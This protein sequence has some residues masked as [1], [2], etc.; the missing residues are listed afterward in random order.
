MIG[1]TIASFLNDPEWARMLPAL[2][3]L[4]THEHGIADLEQR[5]ERHQEEVLGQLIARG[6]AEGVLRADAADPRR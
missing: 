1:R 4:K 5:L 3:L 6:V 2:M